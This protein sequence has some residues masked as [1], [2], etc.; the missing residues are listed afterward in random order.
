MKNNPSES[1]REA[2]EH[3]RDVWVFPWLRH[4]ETERRL[5]KYTLRNYE[6]AVRTLFEWGW[7]QKVG[8]DKPDEL[9]RRSVRSYLVD[10]QRK[11]KR[12]TLHHQVSGIRG[13][14]TFWIRQRK[15]EKNPF[16]AV[17]LPK[18]QKSLPKFLTQPDIEK[19]FRGPLERLQK[20]EIP[21]AQAWRD[22]LV[23]ELLY[24]GGLR[25]SE[26]CQLTYSALDWKNGV[27]RIR[28]KGGKDRMCPLGQTALTCA[29]V[30][31]ETYARH[32]KPT[33]PLVVSNKGEPAYPRMIQLLLKTYLARAALPMDL[34]PHKLRHSFATHLLDNGAG[35]RTV[36]ELLGHSRLST[37]QI[38]T[39]VTMGRLREVYEKA[40]PRA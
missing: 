12:T 32:T 16:E 40:H 26:L 28:G 23:L 3:W 21:A 30:Y 22:L 10:L 20:K 9:D 5:S 15:L 13:F 4:L 37:T 33:D 1:L 6:G 19:L 8:L 17:T 27:A 35:L 25:V 34:T 29:K 39:H 18:M 7:E 24:G 11:V 36:Q 14:F 38:Y 2:W 31:R